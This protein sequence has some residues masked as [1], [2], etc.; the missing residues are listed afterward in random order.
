MSL[1]PRVRF[2]PLPP[3]TFSG[4]PP[5]ANV[6]G[7][8]G[9]N[10]YQVVGGGAQFAEFLV[11]G[12]LNMRGIGTSE[13]FWTLLVVL[14]VPFGWLFPFLLYAARLVARWRP[15]PV[16]VRLVRPRER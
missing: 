13:T 3:I 16:P 10:N 11:D 7:R 6:A 15:S 5:V 14:V 2:R 8:A 12:G 9:D 4:V 1:S